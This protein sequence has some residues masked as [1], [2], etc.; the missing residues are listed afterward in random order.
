MKFL[1]RAEAAGRQLAGGIARE[2]GQLLV[3]FEEWEFQERGSRRH[4]RERIRRQIEND[5]AIEAIG[6]E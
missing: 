1:L 2:R 5:E 6:T 3:D 4:R